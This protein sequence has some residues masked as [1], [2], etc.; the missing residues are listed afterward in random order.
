KPDGTLC[1]TVENIESA[2]RPLLEIACDCPV[3]EFGPRRLIAYQMRLVEQDICRKLVN[4]RVNI[5]R[6]VFKW[7]TANEKVR[8]EIHHGLR[9]VDG[10]KRG[11]CGA[12]ETEPVVS[13]PRADIDAA[14]PFMSE[15]VRAM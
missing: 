8:P 2:L 12:R 9:A 7:G 5:V 11:R 1:R 3:D 4:H 6:R 14:L 13:V 15:P 10:L